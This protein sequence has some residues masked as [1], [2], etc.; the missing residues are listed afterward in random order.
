V[1]RGIGSRLTTDAGSRNARWA[2]DGFHVLFDA[3]SDNEAGIYRKRS[4]GTGSE[5]LVWKTKGRLAD[6]SRDG[7][8]LVQD[9]RSCIVV[10][11]GKQPATTR[12]IA[13]LGKAESLTSGLAS[14]SLNCG[15]FS[16]DGRL[17][18]YTLDLS[19]QPE[20]YVVPFPEGA[21]RIPVSRDGGRVPHWRR[22]GRELFYLSTDG[23]MMSVAVTLAPTL[24]V[25]APQALFRGGVL[26]TG[27][28][29]AYSV[30]SDGQR[31]LMINPLGDPQGDTFTLIAHWSTTLKR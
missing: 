28:A 17:V 15:R 8:L 26:T 22:D 12:V 13:D 30:T 3:R 24:H 16:D 29:P 6:V 21:P 27:P 25:S 14:L 19:G 10:E 18:A 4:D 11:P 5:E 1:S 2:P 9:G 31:F 20:V 23:T 7:R